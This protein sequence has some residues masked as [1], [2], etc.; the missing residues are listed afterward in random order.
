MASKKKRTKK[1]RATRAQHANSSSDAAPHPH[2]KPKLKY[3]VKQKRIQRKALR[4]ALEVGD[5]LLVQDS[6]SATRAKVHQAVVESLKNQ[7]RGSTERDNKPRANASQKLTTQSLIVKTSHGYVEGEE[8]LGVKT[9]RG[10]PFGASTAGNNRFKAPQPPE[11]WSGVRKTTT[12]GN[13]APQPSYGP[14]DKVKGD[15]DCLN[16]DIVRPNN[17]EKL[18]VVVY[19]HGGSFIYGSSHEQLLRGHY[20]AQSMNVVYVAINFRLGA[21]GYLDMRSLGHD[22]VANPAVL[23]QLLALRW[24]KENIAN[25]GGDADNVT[26][27]GESAGGA[28]VLTLMC[29]PAA[30]G[31]FHRA[32]AQSPPIATIHSKAQSKLWTK[33]LLKRLSKNGTPAATLEELRAL[34]AE[35]V[36]RAGQSMMWRSR[37]L[38]HMNACYAPTVDNK[39]IFDHPLT[40]FE[41]GEQHKVPLLIGTNVDEASFA[42]GFYLRT[43]A[44]SKAAAR[45]LKAFDP[46]GADAVLAAY[47]GAETRGKFAHL[48]ADALFWA[49]AVAVASAHSQHASTWMYRFD[50][51]PTVLKWLGMGAMHAAELTPIFGDLTASRVSALNRLG[52][53]D[54]LTLLRDEMQHRWSSFIHGNPPGENWPR[55]GT[56]HGGRPR[57]ATKVFDRTSHTVYDPRAYRRKAWQRYNMTEWGTGRPELIATLGLGDDAAMAAALAEPRAL[58]APSEQG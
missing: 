8:V 25:F 17:D 19:L 22:C 9:W 58:G 4:A 20:L 16:L 36:V 48:L 15:E 1:D 34:P 52:G 29:V 30:K 51:T 45:L 49:P 56:P 41:K 28:A 57:R 21:L 27:M 26:L 38:I 3:R 50:F 33:Q 24:V 55:Y 54:D 44:R 10:I 18:P 39:V 2:E 11:K 47:D 43:T 5:G 32:I 40:V 12:Y 23:D 42:R 13:M 7:E 14:S 37:E 46:H 53:R 35:D 6:P 31:L